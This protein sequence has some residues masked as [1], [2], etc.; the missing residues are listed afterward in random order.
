[1]GENAL[2]QTLAVVHT[3]PDSFC[4]GMKTIPGRAL[5]TH[6]NGDFGAVS[7]TERSCAAP[8]SKLESRIS[9]RCSY[10]TTG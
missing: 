9:D 8:I 3:I 1:M 10:Y 4:A 2:Y 6:K 7:V 5:F